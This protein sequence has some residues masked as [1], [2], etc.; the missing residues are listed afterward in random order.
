MRILSRLFVGSLLLSVVFACSSIR[1]VTYAPNFVYLDKSEV[2]GT[3]HGFAANII[4]IDNIL[5]KNKK[6]SKKQREEIIA[7]LQSI[8]SGAEII[9]ADRGQMSNHMKIGENITEFRNAVE[10][11]KKMAQ[12]NPPNYYYAGQISGR[13]M[14][15]HGK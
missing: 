2:K 5:E 8:Q 15:C 6:V 14:A 12:R 13:C 7:S 11:A 1:K 10:Q 4:K 9:G 3:M